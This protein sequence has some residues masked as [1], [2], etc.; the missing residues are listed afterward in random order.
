MPHKEVT[1]RAD[2]NP[3]QPR[4]TVKTKYV[5]MRLY[6]PKQIVGLYRKNIPVKMLAIL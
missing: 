5:H 1:F 3:T 2:A 6:V 4:I